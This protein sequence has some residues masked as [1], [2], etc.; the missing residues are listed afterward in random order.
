MKISERKSL[1]EHDLA[2]ISAKQLVKKDNSARFKL[3]GGPYHGNTVRLYAPWDLLKYKDP[4]VYYEL[5]PPVD[6]GEDW[7]Y[8]HTE[9]PT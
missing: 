8:I 2:K 4:V 3:V 5:H 6:R 1:I 7:V 9:E